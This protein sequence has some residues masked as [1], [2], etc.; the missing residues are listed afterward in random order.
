MEFVKEDPTIGG[1]TTGRGRW[2]LEP[3]KLVISI[4][5]GLA[6]FVGSF[7]SLNFSNPPFSISIIWNYFPP[8]LAGLAFGWRYGLI[9]G[10]LG[11]G[12]LFAFFIW[13]T[14]GWANIVTSLTSVAFYAWH[15]YFEESRQKKVSPINHPLFI[16]WPYTIIYLIIMRIFYPIAFGFNPPFWE[17]NAELSMPLPILEGIITKGIILMYMG[18][19]FD[20]FILK[21]AQVRSLLGLEIRQESRENA[22]I[23]IKALLSAILAWYTFVI[24]NRI[25][26]DKTFPQGLLTFNDMHE[27]IALVVCLYAAFFMGSI[28]AQ[29]N[30]S[31]LKARDA[32]SES[33]G[34]F[35][36]LAENSTDMIS[37]HDMN[38]VY[39]YV[40]PACRTLLGYEPEEMVGRSAF[41]FIHP[42]DIASVETSRSRIINQRAAPTT[43]FRLR[44]KDGEYIWMETNSHQIIDQKSGAPIEIHAASRDVTGR[45]KAEEA[46]K[47]TESIY[48]DL[49]ETSQDLIWQCDAEGRCSYLNPSW[50]KVFGYKLEEMLGKKFAEFQPPEIAARDE[51]GFARLMQSNTVTSFETTFISKTGKEIHLVFNSKQQTDENDRVIGTLGTAYDITARKL[52]ESA[53][54]ESEERYRTVV[55]N[56]PLVI[57]VTDGNGIFILSDGKGLEKLGLQPGQVVG[58]SVFDVYGDYPDILN[59]LKRA[60]AGQHYRQEVSVQ[61]I[62]FDVVYTPIFDEQEKVTRVIGVA[63]DITERKRSEEALRASEALYRQAIEVAGAVPYR[64]SYNEKM[65]GHTKVIYDFIGEGIRQI[66]G[67]GPEEFNETVWDSL[68]QESFLLENLSA[69]SWVDAVNQVRAGNA[70]IWKCE[71]RIRARDGSIHWVLEAA[72]ELRDEHGVSHGSIGLYQD[73]TAL[74]QAQERIVQLNSDLERRV[75]ERTAQLEDANRE[76]EAFSYSVSHD[77]RA[78]LRAID[79][80]SHLLQEE[81]AKQLPEPGVEMLN[82][83]RAS[84]GRMNQLIDDLLRFSRFSRQPLNIRCINPKEVVEAALEILKGEQNNRQV[85][86]IIGDLPPC[87]ADPSLIA[88]VWTNLLSNA[89]KYSRNRPLT[90][91]EIGS[92]PGDDNRPVYFVRDNGTGFDMRYANRLFGVFQRL[93]SDSEFEGTGVGLAL[94]QRIIA[95][96]GGRIWVESRPDQGATFYFTLGNPEKPNQTQT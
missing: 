79:G 52:A 60:L 17:P 15:G 59:A 83:V 9:S 44:R 19:V 39:R 74:K 67:Y 7:Y 34:R 87:Q 68:I 25:F 22:E 27:I 29:Y 70:P 49:V 90:H 1:N 82:K 18:V 78:P 45:I 47:K 3:K 86:I 32:L 51:K 55:T 94:T 12:G 43:L 75:V 65:T 53:L 14:N 23:F 35:R 85:E 5:L 93:H 50:Q 48:Q 92:L 37:R 2:A 77:L 40:S 80:F 96:H 21:I 42:E 30:E 26:I 10:T 36:L 56:T 69:Y 28:F 11:L 76:L 41:E 88:Q 84:T 13:P 73:V 31:R 16:F 4:L 6:G 33:E 8:L 81:Y 72:V 24:F 58:L 91:I 20:V 54:R 57:F 66:T 64:Q 62:V 63:N 46:L 71:H 95:R 38:G 61:D 89:L